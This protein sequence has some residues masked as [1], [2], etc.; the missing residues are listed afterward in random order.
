MGRQGLLYQETSCA[1]VR[2]RLPPAED[3]AISAMSA[4][5]GSAKAVEGKS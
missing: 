2:V 3:I 4:A 5:F 1:D